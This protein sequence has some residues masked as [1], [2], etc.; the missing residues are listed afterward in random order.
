MERMSIELTVREVLNLMHGELQRRD[1]EVVASGA[2]NL[3][4]VIGDR[5]Q[6]QQVILNL[7][8]NSIEA[9]TTIA[10]DSRRLVIDIF[11]GNDGYAH[12]GISDNG[13]GL[14]PDIADRVFDAFFT[15]KRNGM[16]IGLSICRS[17]IEAHGG[18]IWVSQN[19]PSG[20]VFHF[21]VRLAAEVSSNDQTS[22]PR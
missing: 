9:M 3:L 21:T 6:L 20:S 5:V 12:V 19:I 2:G 18:Q 16:G 14:D 4:E 11:A 7:I 10:Y 1:I 8:M 17:I 15:T 22:Q 13:A